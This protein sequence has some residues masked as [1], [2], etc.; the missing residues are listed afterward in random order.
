MI[1]LYLQPVRARVEEALEKHPDDAVL[2]DSKRLLRIVER[3][4]EALTEILDVV[5][6]TDWKHLN[7][8]GNETLKKRMELWGEDVFDPEGRVRALIAGRE[9]LSYDGTP[10]ES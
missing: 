4:R 8:W 7:S 1:A 5:C 10:R 2:H 6:G 9:A 3:Q